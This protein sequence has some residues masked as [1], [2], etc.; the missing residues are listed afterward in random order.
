MK[1]HRTFASLVRSSRAAAAF[2]VLGLGAGCGGEAPPEMHREG[3]KLA[4]Q[5]NTTSGSYSDETKSTHLWIVDHALDILIRHRNESS[6]GA[7]PIS[8]YIDLLVND[9]T[10][11][12][13]WQHALTDADCKSQYADGATCAD[14]LHSGAYKSHFYDPDTGKNYE[15]ETSPT[16][17]TEAM[18]HFHNAAAYA[19]SGNWSTANSTACDSSQSGVD[20][21]VTSACYELGLSLH[22]MTDITQPMHASNYTFLDGVLGFHSNYED[23]VQ[24]IQSNY[25]VTDWDVFPFFDTARDLDGN[26]KAFIDQAAH[27]AKTEESFLELAAWADWKDPSSGF[28]VG[29]ATQDALGHAQK[30]TAAYLW[31]FAQH[32][33]SLRVPTLH[34]Q[35]DGVEG[36]QLLAH[37]SK[38]QFWTQYANGVGTIWSRDL[39]TGATTSLMTMNAN[40]TGLAVGETYFYWSDNWGTVARALI[41]PAGGTPRVTQYLAGVQSAPEQVFLSDSYV[42]WYN[43]GDQTIRRVQSDGTSLTTLATGEANV[44]ALTVKNSVLYWSR[45]NGVVMKAPKDAA[46]TMLVAASSAQSYG[47]VSDGSYLYWTDINNGFVYR[48]DV[49][50]GFT[51]AIVWKHNSPYAIA[52][53]PDGSQ[54]YFTNASDGTIKSV[55]KNSGNLTTIAWAQ[56]V[57]LRLDVSDRVYWSNRGVNSGI[58]TVV[59]LGVP[60][61]F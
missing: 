55:P 58:G 16:A 4:P 48:T 15:G 44:L 33:S 7:Y 28:Y 12:D 52:L 22:Y 32:L 11:R 51:N 1:T 19:A 49:S 39:K 6:T 31:L 17:L 24:T 57:P 2:A 23:F 8:Q 45:G 10:C 42:Y 53:S 13:R 30:N 29:P 35:G 37:N 25:A 27:D 41:Q 5:W 3:A 47:M 14:P 50:T 36:F 40:P 59:S 21:C 46:P 43:R 26:I 20:G 18:K 9:A 38:R 54:V 61:K 56:D 34:A 60:P